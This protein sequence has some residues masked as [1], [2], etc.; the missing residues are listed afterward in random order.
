RQQIFDRTN[1]VPREMLTRNIPRSLRL[2]RATWWKNIWPAARKWQGEAMKLL[3][4]LDLANA[5]KGSRE[6]ANTLYR[7]LEVAIRDGRLKPGARLPS[8]RSARTA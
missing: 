3:F 2:W 7:Q 6:I 5:P 4:E 1:P 8:T